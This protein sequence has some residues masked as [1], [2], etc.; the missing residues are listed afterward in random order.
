MKKQLFKVGIKHKETGEKLSLQ[1]WAANVNEA[2][3]ELRGVIGPYA[4]YAWTGSGP[5]HDDQGN[6]IVKDIPS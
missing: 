2:A 3:W 5:V 6:V 4:E 1:V